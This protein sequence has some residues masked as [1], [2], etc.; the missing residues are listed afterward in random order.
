MKSQILTAK[1]MKKL[2]VMMFGLM[3]AVSVNAQYLNDPTTPFSQ[4]KVYV[5]ASLSG[6]DLSYS[7]LTD[8]R[9]A[10]QGKVGYFFADNLLGT[11]QLSCDKSKH[12]YAYFSAGAG[13]RYYIEQNGLYLGASAFYRHQSDYDDILPSV[14]L[15]YSFFINRTVTIEPE[16]YYEQSFKNH[17]DYSTLGLRIGIGI[18]LFKNTYQNIR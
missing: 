12:E 16:L 4:G 18:Y 15:G 9:L 10:L 7:G 17:K 14:Q 1:S 5:G 6:M 8:G 13:G 3:A 11:V 2:F